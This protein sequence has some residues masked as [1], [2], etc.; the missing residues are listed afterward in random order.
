MS[1]VENKAFERAKATRRHKSRP[2][3]FRFR[4]ESLRANHNCMTL[5]ALEPFG[6]DLRRSNERPNGYPKGSQQQ[7]VRS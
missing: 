6:K 7:E 4:R 1:E 5:L 2:E 3:R